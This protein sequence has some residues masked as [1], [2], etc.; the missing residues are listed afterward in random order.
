MHQEEE[1][2]G[3]RYSEEEEAIS[4]AQKSSEVWS[5]GDGAEASH[6]PQA[7]PEIAEQQIAEDSEATVIS[8]DEENGDHVGRSQ[9]KRSNQTGTVRRRRRRRNEIRS[10]GDGDDDDKAYLL[11]FLSINLKCLKCSPKDFFDWL[12]CSHGIASLA[13]LLSTMNLNPEFASVMQANGLKG[14]KRGPFMKAVKQ[15]HDDLKASNCSTETTTITEMGSRGK[16]RR[17]C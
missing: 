3:G 15:V 7:L 4:E 14:Y 6:R 16:R 13:S 5:P 8:D 12:V 10:S 9:T 2:S 17:E 11:A 1:E